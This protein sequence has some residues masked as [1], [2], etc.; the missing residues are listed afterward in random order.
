MPP[1]MKHIILT[2]MKVSQ[3]S[4]ATDLREGEIFNSSFRRSFLNLTVRK[5]WNWSTSNKVLPFGAEG[6]GNYAIPCKVHSY[7]RFIRCLF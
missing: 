6:S 1:A 7:A 4:A 5:I 2:D 3:G